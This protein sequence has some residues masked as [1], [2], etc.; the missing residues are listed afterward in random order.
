MATA[1][2]TS[3]QAFI[4]ACNRDGWTWRVRGS[5][6][7]I[8]KQF[9]S[10]STSDFAD[11]DMGY[12]S[13]LALAPRTRPGSDWGT[14]GG[15]IGALSALSSGVFMMNRSGVSKRFLNALSKMS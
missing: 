6:L 4:D 11:C 8:T 3:A 2:Q 5:I 13:I 1:S 12:G 15:G 14:D 10:Q 7:T 9:M